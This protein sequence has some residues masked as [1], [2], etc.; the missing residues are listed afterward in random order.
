MRCTLGTFSVQ[1]LAEEAGHGW[2][3]PRQAMICDPREIAMT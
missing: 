3:Q 1:N 2:D